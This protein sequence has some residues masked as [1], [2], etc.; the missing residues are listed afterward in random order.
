[1]SHLDHAEL[2]DAADGRTALAPGA[3][4]HLAACVRCRADV[5]GLQATLAEA[6]GEVVAEPSPLFWDHFASRVAAAV[7]DEPPASRVAL[8]WSGRPAAAWAALLVVVLV[9]ATFTWRATLHAPPHPGAAGAAPAIATAAGADGAADPDLDHAWR[10]VRAA[11]DDLQWDD[12]Q[13]SGMVGTAGTA[14]RAAAELSP[15][16]RAELARLLESEMRRSGV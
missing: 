6:A 15:E 10:A 2:V 13:A 12:I 1:M 9:S 11:V 16:E 7:R 8:L 4:A 5:E 3:R 14:D